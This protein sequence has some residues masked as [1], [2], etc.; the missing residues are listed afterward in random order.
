MKKKSI[1]KMIVDI[2]ML[3]LMILEFSKLYTGQLFHEIFGITLFILFIIHNVLNI[4]F[5]KNILNGKYSLI[6]VL[7]TTVN[8]L[9][10][11]CMTMTIM[12]G[13]PI[14]SELFKGLN[15][16]GNMTVRKLHTIFGYWDLVL[17][18]IHLGFHYKMIFVKLKNMIKDQKYLKIVV[19]VIDFAIMI[20]GIKVMIDNNIGAYLI[21][22]SSFAKPSNIVLSIFNTSIMAASI[23]IFTY[24]LEKLI[25]RKKG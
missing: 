18:G 1:V 10:L 23:S 4:S 22:K 15:L 20:Y 14:S 8:I 6:R 9:F 3:I 19:Y 5:Y 2:L 12:L 21:G 25:L 13:I 7:L 24:N 16:N 17:L 11:L